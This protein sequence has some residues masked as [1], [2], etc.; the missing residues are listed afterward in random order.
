MIYHH[1][2]IFYYYLN[3]IFENIQE[4]K[5]YFLFRRIIHVFQINYFSEKKYVEFIIILCSTSFFVRFILVYL[6]KL[7]NVLYT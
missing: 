6:T 3:L 1:I 4:N 2:V 5:G 7:C